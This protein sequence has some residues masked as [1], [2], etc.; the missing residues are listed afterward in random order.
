MGALIRAIS[1]VGGIEGAIAGYTPI[2]GTKTTE[3]D[4]RPRSLV[5]DLRLEFRVEHLAGCGLNV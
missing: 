4:A 1:G 5:E 2:A 3:T